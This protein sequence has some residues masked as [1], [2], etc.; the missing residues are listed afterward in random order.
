VLGKVGG[1]RGRV[2]GRTMICLFF[3]R[4]NRPIHKSTSKS[5]Y[6]S[7]R[8]RRSPGE[9]DKEGGE[10]LSLFRPRKHRQE[11]SKEREAALPESDDEDDL[12]VGSQDSLTTAELEA[13]DDY[14]RSLQEILLT[15]FN[16]N[17]LY[18]LQPYSAICPST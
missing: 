2:S 3:F 15:S 4:L 13:M 9:G 17:P 16:L 10:D 8:W 11:T 14:V 1:K 12:F 5:R 18:V 7:D 6:E